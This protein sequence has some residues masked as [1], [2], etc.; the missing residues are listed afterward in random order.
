MLGKFLLLVSLSLAACGPLPRESAPTLA[1]PPSIVP[2]ETAT[3]TPLPTITSTPTPSTAPTITA[4]DFIPSIVA[5][6]GIVAS[7]IVGLGGLAVAALSSYLS[8][9]ERTAPFRVNLYNKKFNIYT[10]IVPTLF[11]AFMITVILQIASRNEDKRMAAVELAQKRSL[12]VLDL[13]QTNAVFLPNAVMVKIEK[14]RSSIVDLIQVCSSSTPNQKTVDEKSKQIGIA[15]RELIEV[16][17]KDLG[18][19]ALTEQTLNLI[20]QSKFEDSA[21]EKL[22]RP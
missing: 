1:S 6:C 21:K 22:T 13:S 2:S 15:Y 18:I 4:M 20:I 10:K 14:F 5:L 12:A 9:R 7:L 3:H 11:D 17:R 16:I 19:E 8:Y